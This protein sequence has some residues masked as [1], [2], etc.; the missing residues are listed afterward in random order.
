MD[1]LKSVPA[2]VDF[3]QKIERLTKAENLP[4]KLI[5]LWEDRYANRPLS[6][7][8]AALMDVASR[9]RNAF[10]SI[11]SHSVSP[12]HVDVVDTSPL[13]VQAML[14]KLEKV[15]HEVVGQGQSG[16][17]IAS[18]RN[19]TI[20]YKVLFALNV[21]PPGT[22]DIAIEADLQKDVAELG[23]VHGVR[24]P[25]ARYFIKNTSIRAIAMERLDAVSF[26]DVLAG[27]AKVPA[28]FEIDK[29]F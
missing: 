1:R 17:V 2:K 24:A 28:S 15:A 29:F 12:A 20:C 25:K 26:K 10:Y 11:E 14:E 4:K 7:L 23:A 13:A 18:L 8:Y 21:Q 3:E 6:E 16:R 22:N 27:T 9:R 19:P 5:T